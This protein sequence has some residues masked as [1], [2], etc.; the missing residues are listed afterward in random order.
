MRKWSKK[1]VV[2]ISK[3]KLQKILFIFGEKIIMYLFY[4]SH[5]PVVSLLKLI[6]KNIIQN[7]ESI[8]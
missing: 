2:V 5:K 6:L 7:N 8:F 3:N 1:N 4:H